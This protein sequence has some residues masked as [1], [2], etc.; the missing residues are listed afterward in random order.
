MRAVTRNA[1]RTLVR[2]L[3][4]T[5]G[6]R[7]LATQS[8]SSSGLSLPTAP[9]TRYTAVSHPENASSVTPKVQALLDRSDAYILPVYARPP[10]VLQRGKGSYVWDV[11]GREYL[12]FSAGIAVNALGHADEGVIETMRTAASNLLHTSNVYH[13]EHA[14]KLAELLI[15][16]TQAE[17]GLGWTPGSSQSWS[18]GSSGAKVF[19]ANTGTEA[20]E[21]ALKIARKVGKARWAEKTGMSWDDASCDKHEIVCFERSFHGR[22]M[23]ALSV[24]SNPKYQKPFMPLIP[25][26][27]VGRLNEQEALK[28]LVDD[29][30]CAVIVEPIQGE[31]G[32][33]AADVEWL[34]ALRK[35]CDEV[36]A[37]LIYDEIQCG[38]YRTGYIWAH[39]TFPADAQPDMVT[40][41]KPL[42]NGY[43]IG[44]VL[45]RDSVAEVMTA[46]THGTT[47]GGSPLACALG[48]HVLSRLSDKA[49]VANVR[50]TGGYLQERLGLLTH[51]FPNILENKVRGRGLILGLGFKNASHPG[52]VVE[53]ARE[54]GVLLLTAGADAVRLVPSL[55]IGAGE[56]GHAMEV[57]E[58]VLHVL[59]EE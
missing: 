36:G 47:F 35:R 25:G 15:T 40:T 7:C 38:L 30:T 45:M 17:G 2:P 39:S 58:S 50:D 8:N 19:F 9:S 54:R 11:E 46:G 21:G 20:N 1:F 43:P 5:L 52:R 24:T 59:N 28:T 29:K 37:V 49:F 53:M 44:A 18:N 48:F 56:V 34:C 6:A 41:A 27:K 22:S 32:I 55:N 57:V 31:G 4:N 51:W 13:N 10:I 33:N 26:V 16:L 23:G 12:D 42:A 14:S 3:K